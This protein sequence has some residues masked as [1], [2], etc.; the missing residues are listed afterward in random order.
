GIHGRVGLRNVPPLQN[1]AFMK[2]YNWDGNKPSL[3]SQALVPIIT[4]EEMNSSILDAI[5]KLHTDTSYRNLFARAFGD[6]RITPDRIYRSLAQY[7]YTLISA[8]S[9]F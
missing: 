1:L 7:Q 8:E 9:K 4:H 2:F 3:E 6:N 5:E